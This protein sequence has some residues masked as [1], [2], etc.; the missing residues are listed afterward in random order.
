MAV[1]IWIITKIVDFFGL[2]DSDRYIA[3][4]QFAKGHYI[5]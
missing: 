5:L 4:A 2:I 3:Q 1:Q